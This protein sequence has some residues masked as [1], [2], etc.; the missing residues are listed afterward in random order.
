VKR[1]GRGQVSVEFLMILA[2]SIVIITVIAILAQGQMA[3]VQKQKDASDAQNSLYDLSAAA[4][5]VYAQGEGSK[6]MV[7]IRLPG[8][9]EPDRS[10]VVNR[11][12]QIRAGGT[13]Y[14]ALE[15]FN[16]RGYLP[17]TSGGHWVWVVSE[18]N[19]VRIGL[20]MFALDRNRIYL[21][22]DSNTSADQPFSV[23]N[24]WVRNI[25]LSTASTWVHTDVSM[26]GL[27]SGFQLE[28]NASGHITMHFVASSTARGFYTG[29]I[30][31]DATDGQGAVETA[32]IPV[33]VQVIGPGEALPVTD[34][35]GP[36]ITSISQDPTPATKLQ[37]LTIFVTAS[38]ELT[39]NST[40]KGCE[41]D[42]DQANSWKALIPTDGAYDQPVEGSSYVF[43]SGFSLGPHTIRA[44]CVDA[45]NNTG[46]TGYYYFNVTEADQLGPIVISMS[47]TGYPT[48]LSN[49][50]V[51]GVAT[52]VYTGGSGVQGCKVKL[53][54]GDWAD[55][56]AD[57]GAW[58]SSTE[59]FTYS[60]GALGVGYHSVYYQ[61]TDTVGNIGGIYNDSFGV[62]DVDLMIV[63][64]RSGSMVWMVTNASDTTI[65]STTNTGWTRL[66]NITV[67]EK[68]GDIANLTAEIRTSASG[69]TAF[70]EARIN[71]VVVGSGNTTSTA[72]V[73]VTNS[74]DVSSFEAPYD[75]A[76]YMKRA[77]T[78][79]CTVYDR[80]LGLHQRPSK[81]DASKGSAK[82]FLDIS[83]SATYAGMASYSTTAS[84]DRTLAVMDPANLQAL[85]NSIDA[86]SA[87]GSTCIEC[88]L[89]YAADELVSARGRP[90]STR[91]IIMLTDGVGNTGLSGASCGTECSVNGAVYCR[92]RNI[93]VYTIGFGNDVDDVELTNIALLTNGEYYFAPNAETLT[94]IFMNIGK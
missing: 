61:C 7:F 54:S 4:K 17:A 8:S 84:T 73:P 51:G 53:D 86:L 13:D 35:L 63:L 44:R 46:P 18:G 87:V 29:E 34:R 26:S 37:P 22:M 14:V 90:T 60:V 45:V 47:H 66:K 36:I 27:P 43:T 70:Y 16:V 38:D 65:V 64:D 28:T 41:I 24:A 57:D 85:K 77:S 6:K 72:Y 12:I 68:N 75:V 55:A 67:T 49:V 58:D 83:G 32:T 31:L 71:G 80:M 5:E 52:D 94:D 79:S 89:V 39:G 74:I 81:M 93:T 56:S 9:Y 59:N 88:G 91:V 42:A 82:T 69:C 30:E 92:E 40:I 1:I 15:D 3:A 48:T 78:L 2:I 21:V 50:T 33:T 23:T 76:L 20:A 62:V 19:R 11:S 25:S 10:F